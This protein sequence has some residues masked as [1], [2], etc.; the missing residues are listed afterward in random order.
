[1]TVDEGG[2]GSY[3]VVLDT[4]PAA[5]VTVAIQVPDNADI[6]VDKTGIDLHSSQLEYRCRR[7]R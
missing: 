3:T 5:D 7:S 2:S 6:A 4:E 1:M